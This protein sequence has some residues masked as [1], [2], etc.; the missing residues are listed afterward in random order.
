MVRY[1]VALSLAVLLLGACGPLLSSRPSE[2]SLVIQRPVALDEANVKMLDAQLRAFSAQNNLKF[3]MNGAPGAGPSFA[4]EM[5]DPSK[6]NSFTV[7]SPF[8][9]NKFMFGYYS[10]FRDVESLNR[11]RSLFERLIRTATKSAN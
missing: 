10:S 7:T 8:E 2:L 6:R 9:A 5:T 3:S 11:G 1:C 4:V